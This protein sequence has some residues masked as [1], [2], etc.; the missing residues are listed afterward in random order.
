LLH[1]H[2]IVPICYQSTAK[3]ASRPY[4][5]EANEYDP[6]LDLFNDLK[7]T[8]IESE[9]SADFHNSTRI[10]PPMMIVA[11]DLKVNQDR[12]KASV[13]RILK[14][15]NFKQSSNETEK[16]DNGPSSYRSVSQTKSA[17]DKHQKTN[18]VILQEDGTRAPSVASLH[19]TVRPATKHCSYQYSTAAT[20][21]KEN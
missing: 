12:I 20:A 2:D 7:I 9:E 19:T 3:K 17:L 4:D 18:V 10:E 13:K 6:V 21:S 11:S 16:S 14:Q 15:V 1:F 5:E 8:R